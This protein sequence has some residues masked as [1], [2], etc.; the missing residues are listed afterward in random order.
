MREEA[1]SQDGTGH[2]WLPPSGQGDLCWS[3][4]AGSWGCL[5]QGHGTEPG[6]QASFC[7]EAGVGMDGTCPQGR[8][9][10]AACSPQGELHTVRNLSREPIPKI[11]GL[12]VR[13]LQLELTPGQQI[14]RLH[15][16]TAA[17][18]RSTTCLSHTDQC[19][20]VTA[21]SEA[22]KQGQETAGKVAL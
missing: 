3:T 15:G 19:L 12:G 22:A 7:G 18:A 5:P 17:P 2:S 20:Q 4:K 1:G 9:K 14:Q 21:L 11:G 6:S 8:R 16:K 10:Q 13:E